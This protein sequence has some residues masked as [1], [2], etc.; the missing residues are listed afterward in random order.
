V[1]LSN[2]EFKL[3]RPLRLL[4]LIGVAVLP[5]VLLSSAS[6][7]FS[8]LFHEPKPPG[9]TLFLLVKLSGLYALYLI[10]LQI[11]FALLKPKRNF[12]VSINWSHKAHIFIG[13]LIAGLIGLHVLLFLAASWQRTGIFPWGA[14]IPKLDHG[15]YQQRLA[16]GVIALWLTSV[17]LFAGMR[18]KI[19]TGSFWASTHKVAFVV[20][21][22]VIIHSTS[23]G[24]ET[25]SVLARLFYLGLVL[26][27]ISA[28]VVALLRTRM[29]GK[30]RQKL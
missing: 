4:I 15:Y 20:F 3:K 23:I 24:S 6:D 29:T 5:I 12:I 25:Q 1:E 10:A 8:G 21:V 11:I 22:L 2:T 7:Y 16:A 14:F 30:S 9:Q 27:V 19:V 26:G 17:L 28:C 13:L 18:R